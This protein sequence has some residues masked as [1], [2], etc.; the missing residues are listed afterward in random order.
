MKIAGVR[1]SPSTETVKRMMGVRNSGSREAENRTREL[2]A[3]R[4]QVGTKGGNRFAQLYSGT[5]MLEL[6]DFGQ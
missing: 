1:I 3:A 4:I 6:F 2:A 5:K